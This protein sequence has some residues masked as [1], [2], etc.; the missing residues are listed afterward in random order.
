MSEWFKKIVGIILIGATLV[1]CI[2]PVLKPEDVR[3]EHY[4]SGGMSVSRIR[5][6]E[7]ERNG[8]ILINYADSEDLT[9]LKGIGQSIASHILHER[10]KNGPFY[11]AEDLE[12]VKGIGPATLL[13]FRRQIDMETEESRE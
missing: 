13:Q 3:T 12:S 10:I 11:Y 7:V 6:I 4:H 5:P 2:F 1:L 9:D 8:P